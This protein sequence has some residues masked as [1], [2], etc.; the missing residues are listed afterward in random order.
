MANINIDMDSNSLAKIKVIGVGGGGNNAISRMRENGLSGVEFLA[1]NTDLQTLQE[2]NADLRLQIGE[3]LTRGLGAG[4][5]PSVGEKAAEESKSEIE[6]AIKGADMVFITAG[7]GGGTGT[8]AAPVV[9]QVAKEMD[10]L[11]V[12]VVTKPFTF[13]GRKRATQA[14][15]GIEKLKEN[16]DTLITIPNDR[17]LQIVEKRTSMVE[18]FQMADQVLM[19][20]VSGISELIAVPNVINLDFADVESIMS[21]QGIAHMGIGRA[22]GE[23]RAVDAA[24]AAVNSP[25]LETSIEGANAVLLN[26]TAAEVG[27]MEAN[28]AAELIRESIDSDANIIF[29]VG[30][31]ESLGE[32][33]KIT[34]IATGFDNTARSRRTDRNSNRADELRAPQ[35]NTQNTQSTQNRRSSNPF[36]DIELPDFLK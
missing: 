7:M 2:S 13:E 6:E 36:D 24:K 9:A 4:A 3:K 11:T 25:L 1:L 5:N 34:V 12:G 22:S 32:E 10:I 17:L 27:L 19:D 28:E 18:A 26:V 15:S 23:N 20:A 29:G 21:D 31:D 30:S 8:G 16:V 33:I 14:E 35:R